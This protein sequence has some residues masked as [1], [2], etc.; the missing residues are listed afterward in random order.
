MVAFASLLATDGTVI[1]LFAPSPPC[2]LCNFGITDWDC[3]GANQPAIVM[4]DYPCYRRAEFGRR[5]KARFALAAEHPDHDAYERSDKNKKVD[6]RGH[7]YSPRYCPAVRAS[8]CG[9]QW[10]V[11]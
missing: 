10:G 11:V 9:Q 6:C 5:L 3:S 4:T 7:S 1:H 8:D 2:V